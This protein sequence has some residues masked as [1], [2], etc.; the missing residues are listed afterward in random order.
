MPE[1]QIEKIARVM[2]ECG[3]GTDITRVLRDQGL[4]DSSGQSTK[5]RRLYWVFLDL[6]RRDGC[7][8]RVL[9][10]IQSFLTPSRFVG[11]QAAF[12]EHRGELNPVLLFSGLE[13][14]ADGQFRRREAAKTLGEAER[15]VRTIHT[16]FQG[17]RLHLEVLKY[18]KAELMQDNYFPRRI[19]GHQ[20]LG[21]ANPRNDGNSGRRSS[22]GR[23]C[24]L[25]RPTAS[26]HEHAPN[27]YGEVTTQGIRSSA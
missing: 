24:F 5:W 27:R 18:C 20:R 8:N 10:F 17:R 23:P 2:G 7:A 16:K 19:R 21:T 15:R 1:G 11:R 3:S 12:D 25:C 22:L 13:F 4:T 6:Q 9:S 26:R 14:S